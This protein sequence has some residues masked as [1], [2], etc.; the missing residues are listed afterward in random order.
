M[1]DRQESHQPTRPPAKAAET[2]RPDVPELEGEMPL[3]EE[4][5]GRASG[6]NETL[7]ALF[8]NDS[9][10]HLADGFRGGSNADEDVA[11]PRAHE[12]DPEADPC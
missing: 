2:S 9:A 12:P 11:I 3:P 10:G 6:T 5:T 1:P 7:T 4:L 8:G